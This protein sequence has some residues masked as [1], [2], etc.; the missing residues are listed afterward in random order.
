MPRRKATGAEK[1]YPL[2]MRTTKA[3]RER[4]ERAARASGRS[5]IKEVERRLDESSRAMG[6]PAI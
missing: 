1:R 3:Q 6:S 5:L 4:L 2:N